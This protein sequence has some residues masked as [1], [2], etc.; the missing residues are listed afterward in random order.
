MST[1]SRSREEVTDIPE[2]PAPAPNL[3]VA[4]VARRLGV[5]PPTL[6]T[7]DRRYGL[8]P[9][10]HTAGA[11]RRYSPSDVARLMVMRR[12]TLQGVAPAD[13]ARVALDVDVSR[14]HD[15]SSAIPP[16]MAALDPGPQEL[17]LPA[18]VDGF[19]DPAPDA[20]PDGGSWLREPPG[21]P[22]GSPSDGTPQPDADGW[23]GPGE[24]VGPDGAAW[25]ERAESPELPTLPGWLR[26]GPGGGGRVVALPDGTPRNRGLA[27]A[28]MSLDTGEM[29]RMLV[30]AVREDGVCE[31]WIDM[32][33]PV[34]RA[35]GERT[36]ATG[37]GVDV[38]HAFSEV[39]LGVFRSPSAYIRRPR[40]LAPV[41]LACADGDYH[42]LPLHALAAAL[43]ERQITTRMLGTGL[44]PA[45]LASSVRRTGPSAIALFA[46]MPGADA[47]PSEQLRRQR[48]AP[49]VVLCGPGWDA[50]TVPSFA[51]RAESLSEAV[52]EVV[53]AAQA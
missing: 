18:G 46:R 11:H 38:E 20:G 5:A 17:R 32:I 33:M 1:A 24:P 37:D 13:A 35:L 28:A 34:L 39:V 2:A 7:W 9:S 26:F 51:R 42:S 53:L 16:P 49:A 25:P 22:A 52:D 47:G 43:A 19:A 50:Q 8:G 36:V 23:A 3:T 4:A 44:P 31:T 45:A 10:E 48:P 41:L 14:G 40:N 27:R 30:D 6:R 21:D 15:P 12:L 29:H